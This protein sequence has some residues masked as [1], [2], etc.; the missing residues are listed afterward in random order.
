MTSARLRGGKISILQLRQ[1]DGDV[2]LDWIAAL[3]WRSEYCLLHGDG[4]VLSNACVETLRIWRLDAQRRNSAQISLRR[5][6]ETLMH[7][8]QASSDYRP[9]DLRFNYLAGELQE[10]FLLAFGG[11]YFLSFLSGFSF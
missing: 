2:D 8:F 3:V 9:D 7:T 4:E 1:G 10:T 5:A 11:G 6:M